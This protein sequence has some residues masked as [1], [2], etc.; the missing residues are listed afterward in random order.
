MEH[1]KTG[2]EERRADRGRAF[3]NEEGCAASKAWQLVSE[4]LM[5]KDHG[6]DT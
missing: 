1:G 2:A 3:F 4:R 6:T 5:L